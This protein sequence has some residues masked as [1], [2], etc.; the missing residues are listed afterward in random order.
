[1]RCSLE[2][3]AETRRIWN[4]HYH[5]G[6]KAKIQVQPGSTWRLRR[7]Q[8]LHLTTSLEMADWVYI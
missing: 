2:S 6:R 4:A 1:M 5:D 7:M 3:K 8:C